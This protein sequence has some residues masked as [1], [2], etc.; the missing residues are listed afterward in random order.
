MELNTVSLD[1][2]NAAASKAA[3]QWSDGV[4]VQESLAGAMARHFTEET[5]EGDDEEAA[6]AALQSIIDD[7]TDEAY[8]ELRERFEDAVQERRQNHLKQEF[9]RLLS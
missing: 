7:M 2:V 3:G 6:D 5:G 1:T 8:A 9:S 4:D